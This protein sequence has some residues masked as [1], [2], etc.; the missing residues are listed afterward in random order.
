MAPQP[1][2]VH[3]PPASVAQRIEQEPSN[4]LVGGSIPSRGTQRAALNCGNVVQGRSWIYAVPTVPNVL[5]S[6][7]ITTCPATW[8]DVKKLSASAVRASKCLKSSKPQEKPRTKGLFGRSV[9]PWWPP[10]T[11]GAVWSERCWPPPSGVLFGHEGAEAK[12]TYGSVKITA[13]YGCRGASQQGGALT[14]CWSG[15]P[16]DCTGRRP[17]D[18]KNATRPKRIPNG[19][20]STWKSDGL[21]CQLSPRETMK[22]LD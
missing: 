3:T 11:A 20:G 19:C 5:G 10:V 1:R 9:V 17:H 18:G 8:P 21:A 14:R 6:A 16:Q 12:A 13:L 15:P 2:A 7:A 4:L 22:H